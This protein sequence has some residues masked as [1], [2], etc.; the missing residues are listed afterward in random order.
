MEDCGYRKRPRRHLRCVAPYAAG[1]LGV[2]RRLA[3]GETQ[4]EQAGANA[5]AVA[6]AP[7]DAERAL[8]RLDRFIDAF[9]VET[10]DPDVVVEARELFAVV[11]RALFES[12]AGFAEHASRLRPVGLIERYGTP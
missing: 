5:R 11:G 2:S 10:H 12:R 1:E 6:E 3:E 9:L 8:E 7:L 4:I